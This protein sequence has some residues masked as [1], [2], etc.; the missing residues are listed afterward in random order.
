[1][2][3]ASALLAAIGLGV[4]AVGYELGVAPVAAGLFGLGFGTAAGDV[5][6]NVHGAAVERSLGRAIMPRFHA[7][8]SLGTV[9]GAGLGTLMVACRVPVSVHL[10]AVALAV[11]VVLPVAARRFLPRSAPPPAWPHRRPRQPARGVGRDA[12]PDDRLVRAVRDRH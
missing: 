8:W 10:L 3:V 7:G 11:G 5:A 4:A 2:T 12:D 6:I 9:A 1:M